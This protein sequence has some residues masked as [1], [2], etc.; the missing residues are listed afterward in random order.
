MSDLTKAKQNLMLYL[1]LRDRYLTT[2]FLKKQF[3]I[4]HFYWKDMVTHQVKC[5]IVP[6]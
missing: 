2:I 5:F 4:T 3:S 6:A 1:M